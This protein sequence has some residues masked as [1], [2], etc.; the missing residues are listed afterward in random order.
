MESG[1]QEKH[2]NDADSL[3]RHLSAPTRDS[4]SDGEVI[5]RGKFRQNGVG[6]R[7]SLGLDLAVAA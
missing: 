6:C 5:Y 1:I 2:F 3:W 4:D 7:T